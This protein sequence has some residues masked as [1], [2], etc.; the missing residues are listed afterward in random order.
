MYIAMW[1]A[2]L[3]M[4]LLTWYM[5]YTHTVHEEYKINYY[6]KVNYTLPTSCNAAKW[7]CHVPQHAHVHISH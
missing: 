6:Q 2:E 5:L 7:L 1:T 3:T 4:Q